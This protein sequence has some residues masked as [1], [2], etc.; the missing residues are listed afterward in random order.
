VLQNDIDLSSESL[1]GAASERRSVTVSD[2]ASGPITVAQSAST[3]RATSRLRAK[4]GLCPM[5]I[6]VTLTIRF[7][8]FVN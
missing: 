7:L 6:E 1:S 8:N 5:T 4:L 3:T 2:H